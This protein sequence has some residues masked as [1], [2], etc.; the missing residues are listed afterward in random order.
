MALAKESNTLIVLSRGVRSG[1][2]LR[3][4]WHTEGWE[5]LWG[6]LKTPPSPIRSEKSRLGD[7]PPSY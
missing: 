1:G 2:A 7:C 4:V 6:G 3:I 5:P